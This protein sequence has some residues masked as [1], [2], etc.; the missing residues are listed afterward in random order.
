[1]DNFGYRVSFSTFPNEKKEITQL[2][3]SCINPFNAT[4][5]RI[6]KLIDH[7][8]PNGIYNI[9]FLKV[10]FDKYFYL[11]NNIRA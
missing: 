6:I 7:P 11:A 8:I 4:N 10:V 1:M 9:S 3:K 5:L 2:A